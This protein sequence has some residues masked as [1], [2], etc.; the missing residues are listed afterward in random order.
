L[1]A[2]SG[3]GDQDVRKTFILFGDPLMRLKI[4]N[5]LPQITNPTAQTSTQRKPSASSGAAV[6]RD[7]R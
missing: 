5:G 4:P 2:K 3:I 6:E 1:F 7:N